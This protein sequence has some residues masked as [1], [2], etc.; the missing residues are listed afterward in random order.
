MPPDGRPPAKC[1]VART[2][3]LRGTVF[4]HLDPRRHG[5]DVPQWLRDQPHVVLQIGLDMPIPIP[6]LRIDA[7]GMH[8]TLSFHRAP[9][10]CRV[11]WDSVFALVGEDGRGM[12][13]PEAIPPEI[14]SEIAAMRRGG[15]PRDVVRVTRGRASPDPGPARRPASARVGASAAE[16][17]T[18]GPGIRFEVIDGEG[19]SSGRKGVR[20]GRAHLRLVKS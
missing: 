1:D 6:D 17:R 10:T 18:A 8:A 7:V 12:V 3:L 2:L 19:R 5:V 20:A 15:E 4:V 13:W 14:A 11:P 9:Y 16:T